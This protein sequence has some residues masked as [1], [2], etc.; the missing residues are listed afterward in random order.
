[1]VND[2]REKCTSRMLSPCSVLLAICI[3][4]SKL[5]DKLFWQSTSQC[6]GEAQFAGGLTHPFL[7]GNLLW[8]H[9]TWC[10]PMVFSWKSGISVHCSVLRFLLR[11]RFSI[12][13]KKKKIKQSLVI[14]LLSLWILAG[15]GSSPL[16]KETALDNRKGY[17]AAFCNSIYKLEEPKQ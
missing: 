17:E 2:V 7:R 15:I 9:K 13:Q 11:F 6:Y 3:A 8:S 4:N 1:M 10:I 16:T 5:W 12:H 14:A